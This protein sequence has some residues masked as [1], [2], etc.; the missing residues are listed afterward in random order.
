MI[1]V[2]LRFLDFINSLFLS[3]AQRFLFSNTLVIYEVILA[4]YNKVKYTVFTCW[5]RKLYSRNSAFSVTVFQSKKTSASL[6]EE[7]WSHT[8]LLARFLKWLSQ[9]TLY[10]NVRF[11]GLSRWLVDDR[12]DNCNFVTSYLNTHIFCVCAVWSHF[13]WI[14]NATPPLLLLTR[15]Y[16]KIWSLYVVLV[17]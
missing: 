11:L 12:Y 3:L 15:F 14:N 17:Y 9:Y 8:K 16:W 1:N 5:L 4:D 13:H 2:I 7:D 10:I 6:Y